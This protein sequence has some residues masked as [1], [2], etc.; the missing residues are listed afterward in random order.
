MT[1]EEAKTKWCPMVRGTYSNRYV[2]EIGFSKDQACLASGCA[3][4]RWENT[5]FVKGTEEDKHLAGYCGL[6]GKP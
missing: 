1:E 4:W 6:G 5:S 3:L 2:S